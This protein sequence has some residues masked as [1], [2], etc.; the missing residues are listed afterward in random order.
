MV[1]KLNVRLFIGVC[2]CDRMNDSQ[3]ALFFYQSGPIEWRPRSPDLS[4][5]DFWL[6]GYLHDN[7]FQEPRA[8]NLQVLSIVVVLEGAEGEVIVISER[9]ADY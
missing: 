9:G 6:W 4:I 5:N 7:V 3:K 1:G 2:T 8:E